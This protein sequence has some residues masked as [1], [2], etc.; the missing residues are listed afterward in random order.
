MNEGRNGPKLWHV[1]GVSSRVKEVQVIP[2][3]A[4]AVIGT[5]MLAAVVHAAAAIDPEPIPWRDNYLSALKE[6]DRLGRPVFMAFSAEWCG[7]CRQMEAT[8]YRD[9]A[10]VL[11]LRVF[12]PLRVEFFSGSG[13]AS[14]FQVALIPTMIVLDGKGDVIARHLGSRSSEEMLRSLRAVQDGYADYLR[15]LGALADFAA[16]RRVATYLVKLRNSGRAVAILESGLTQIPK[17]DAQ[18]RERAQL[19]VAEARELAGDLAGAASLYTKLSQAATER[20]LRAKALF[21]LASV[22]RR[23]GRPR[24]ATEDF[25]RLAREFP[26][27][28]ESVERRDKATAEPAR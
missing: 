19:D 20:E 28:A 11:A 4:A 18:S 25:D 7:P 24:K 17:S 2:R 21:K 1:S 13:L 5:A 9:E 14:K 26:D 16:C 8:T 10:V 23:R 6:A 3:V 27:F 22:E 15:D 12:V